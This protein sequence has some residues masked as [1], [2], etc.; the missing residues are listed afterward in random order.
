MKYNM[1]TIY[2]NNKKIICHIINILIIFTLCL[3]YYCI[4]IYLNP[5]YVPIYRLVNNLPL[6]L[7]DLCT[8]LWF[9]CITLIFLFLLVMYNFN[10]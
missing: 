2:D 10:Y 5:I 8:G 7:S 4:L 9:P 3:S 1:L 6:I